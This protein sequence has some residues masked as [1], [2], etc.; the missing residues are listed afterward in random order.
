MKWIKVIGFGVLLW[1]L[2]FAIVSA[3]IAFDIYKFVWMQA[4]TAIVAGIISFILAGKIKPD[5]LSL[6]ISYG[7]IWVIAGLILDATVTMKFNSE[8]FLSW[9]LW[10]GYILILLAPVLRIKKSQS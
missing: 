4:I 3:F 10:A 9:S 1:I 6:A 2:M 8:I 5:K 7:L